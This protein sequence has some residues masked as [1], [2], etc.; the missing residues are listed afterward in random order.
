MRDTTH[1]HRR[2]WFGGFTIGLLALAA[3][4]VF[5]I[6]T[7]HG[8]HMLAYAPFLILLACPF[9]HS[10]MHGGHGHGDHRQ[11]QRHERADSANATG[12]K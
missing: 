9:L 7:G 11:G 8:Y 1:A 6:L 3:I 10:F 5:L 4:V 2:R 12:T